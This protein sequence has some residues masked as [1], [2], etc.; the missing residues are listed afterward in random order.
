MFRTP[1]LRNAATRRVFFHNGRYHSVGAVLAFYALRDAAPDSVYPTDSDG[2]ADRF[3]DL[4]AAYRANVDVTD[5][6]FG[7]P[8]GAPSP[9]S[10]QDRRAIVAFLATLTDGYRAGVRPDTAA[11]SGESSRPAPGATRRPS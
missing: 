9:L 10:V 2:R 6:P 1:S 5:P 11:R 4:P 8:A 3:D 7:R